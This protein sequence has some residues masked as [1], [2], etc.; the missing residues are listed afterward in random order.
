M[1]GTGAPR[2]RRLAAGTPWWVPVLAVAGIPAVVVAF[3]ARGRRRAAAALV[4]GTT[5]AMVVFFRDPDRSAGS[6][7]VLAPA[8]GVVSAVE[9]HPDGRVRIS[10]FMRLTDVHVNRAPM[11]G[12][13][14]ARRH[15]PG[16]HRPAFLPAAH[17]NERM[18]WT[19]ETSLGDL[20]LV[21]IAGS[22][23][24]R[25]IPYKAPGERLVRGERIGMIRF[26]SRVD[27][28]LPEGV[29]SGV[30]VGARVRAGVTRLDRPTDESQ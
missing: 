18:E 25:I 6:G 16:R 26:G 2:P 7:V 15:V 1:T 5:A 17:A 30:Q 12:V 11:D 8:D 29:R 28:L 20:R 24:R 19:I 23:A 27:V 21:Q 9:R 13:V 22:L 10:T 4:A 3:R 14:R